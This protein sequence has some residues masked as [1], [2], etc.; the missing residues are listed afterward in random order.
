MNNQ[1]Y[2]IALMLAVVLVV[3]PSSAYAVSTPSHSYLWG[4]ELLLQPKPWYATEIAIEIADNVI[5]Y[6]S[7]QGGWPKNINLAVPP[8][9]S[10]NAAQES[11]KGF[12]TI[13]N[14]AT[15]R[16][17][18]FIAQIYSATEEER[19][20]QSFERGLMYLL[21]AQ[22]DNG[23][24]PQFWPLLGDSY[25]SRATFN[26]GAMINVMQLLRDTSTEEA[27][28]FVPEQ[29]RKSSAEAVAQGVAF[30]LQ[31]QIKQNGRLTVWCAQH[32]EITLQPAW[33][34]AYEPPSLSGSESVGIVRFLMSID[35]PS[36]EVVNAIESAVSWLRDNAITGQKMT[37]L[38]LPDGTIERKITE[39]LT[40]PPIWARFY[41]LQ[42]NRPLFMD[43]D[44]IFNYDYSRLSQERRNGY[45]YLGYWPT[46]LLNKEYPLWQA[47]R[48]E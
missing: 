27:Y 40:A 43:R 7:K 13:D 45:G 26:D 2:S 36:I 33:A 4:A 39:D 14:D 18:R 25:H 21:D 8:K 22:Y 38:E 29:L 32:H 31:S 17:M 19:F 47:K 37:R 42:T 10:I 48:T 1:F 15:T 6:Q 41:E 3:G 30:I 11:I 28:S 35:D 46:H 24:W 44:S 12:A 5:Q 34:R 16:P 23:G 20:K 9:P